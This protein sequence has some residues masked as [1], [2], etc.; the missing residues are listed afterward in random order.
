MPTEFAAPCPS[1]PVVHSTPVVMRYS[2]WPGVRLSSCRKDLMSS[3]ETAG[4]SSTRP[5]RST[6]RTPVR[7]STE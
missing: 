7:W 4:A 3:S 5:S 2:G 6:W 1:G